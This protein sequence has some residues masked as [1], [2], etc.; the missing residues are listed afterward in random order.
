MTTIS[1]WIERLKAHGGN[2]VEELASKKEVFELMKRWHL[3]FDND[4]C[5]TR[6]GRASD[7]VPSICGEMYLISA[8][9]D[10][11]FPC[12]VAPTRFALLVQAPPRAEELFAEIPGEFVLFDKAFTWSR[13]VNHEEFLTL[14]TSL[15]LAPQTK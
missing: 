6:A 15:K 8:F 14:F 4:Y 13:V 9:L 10:P 1:N 2:V 3:A 5:S 11:I 7:S 12:H